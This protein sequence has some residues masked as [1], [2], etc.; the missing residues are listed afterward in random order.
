ME[1]LH[2]IQTHSRNY[3]KKYWDK[4]EKWLESVRD[5]NRGKYEIDYLSYK[6]HRVCYA[7]VMRQLKYSPVGMEYF[8]VRWFR[9]HFLRE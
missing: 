4:Y 6:Y 3:P 9:S 8:Q 2:L 7:E 1:H 5:Y